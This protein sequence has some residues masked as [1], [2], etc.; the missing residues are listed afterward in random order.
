MRFGISVSI[1]EQ[2]LIIGANQKVEDQ[3]A[4]RRQLPKGAAYIFERNADGIWV[5]VQKIVATDEETGHGFG[6][7]VTIA[8]NQAIVGSRGPQSGGHGDHTLSEANA[9]YIYER[10]AAGR[11]Q[12]TQK[13][14]HPKQIFRSLEKLYHSCLLYTS[15]SPRDRTR[16]RMP[17][18]A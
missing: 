1:S 12:E 7:L 8:D 6:Y 9:V 14:M 16:S 4:S 15:P 11:W 10:N 2:Y 17:S 13:I 18:S 5:E 3:S